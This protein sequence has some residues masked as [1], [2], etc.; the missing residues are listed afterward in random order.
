M[1]VLM[2]NGRVIY[3]LILFLLGCFALPRTGLAAEPGAALLKAKKEAES[4]EFIFETSRDAI[5]A[6]AKK[7]GALKVLSGLDPSVY[8]SMMAG[9]KKKYPFLKIEMAEITGPDSA[10]R[11]IL[12]LQSGSRNDFDVV[13]ASTEFYPEYI[14]FAKKFDLLGMAEHGVLRIPTKMIDPQR[15]S[16]AALGSALSA[17]AYNKNMIPPEKVPNRWEDFLKP[18]FRGRKFMVDMRPHAFAAYPACP[19][20]GLGLEWMLKYAKG[21]R[22]QDP[23]WSRGHSRAISSIQAGEHAI[24]SGTHYHS[25]VRAMAK[26]PTG[27]LQLKLVEPVP[28]RL[29]QLEL[30]LASAPHPYAALLYL[31]HEAS[32]EGQEVI[33][34]HVVGSILYPASST[35]KAIQGKKTCINSFAD[36]HNS[37][38]WMAMAVEAFGFPKDS[39]K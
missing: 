16:F 35:A 28:V 5:I 23:V 37:D 17:V 30:V 14:P 34:K 2:K 39:A 36:F 3:V 22:E 7:E 19:Q 18:E 21:L 8:S 9:F 10:Q 13:H 15:R 4:K 12:E 33:D 1:E 32:P 31:E 6:K 11:F 25:L 24:H 26:D 38:K 20:E 29:T 27:A